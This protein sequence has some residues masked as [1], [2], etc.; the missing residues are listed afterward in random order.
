MKYTVL[1]NAGEYAI[2]IF[3]TEQEAQD[4]AINYHARSQG[5]SLEEAEEDLEM[6]SDPARVVNI[7]EEEA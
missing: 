6:D 2:G 1:I 4:F 3:D 7:Y 5:L